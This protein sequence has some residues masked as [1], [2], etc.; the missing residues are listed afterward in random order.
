MYDTLCTADDNAHTLSHPT[1]V[2]MMSLLLQAGQHSPCIRH[3][4][5]LLSDIIWTIYNI[6][7]NPYIITLLCLW[8]HSLY[9]WNHIQ[10]E[11]N[12]YTIR[13]T[14]Q[15]PSVSSPTLYRQHHTHSF[16]DITLAL[17]AASFAVYKYR[18]LTFWPQTTILRT[19]HPLY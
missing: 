8:H 2:F 17:C 6:T 7:A 15:P 13:V 4:T 16:Y 14:S 1:T 3:Q 12:I 10:Y 19:S 9:I 18:I 5:H 11:G